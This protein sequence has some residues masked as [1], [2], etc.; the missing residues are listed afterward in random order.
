MVLSKLATQQHFHNQ[1]GKHQSRIARLGIT[2]HRPIRRRRLS[3][4][5]LYSHLVALFAPF[6]VRLANATVELR[7]FYPHAFL[8]GSKRA[9]PH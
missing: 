3:V 9:I 6:G 5:H 2:T 1:A 7:R 8:I 4:S